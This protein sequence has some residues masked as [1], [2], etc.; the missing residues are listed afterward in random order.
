MAE[1]KVTFNVAPNDSRTIEISSGKIA[2][3][4]NGSCVVR[5]GDT[6]VM[7]AACSGDAKPGQDFFPL[8]VD[9]REKYS[10]AGKFPRR[11]YQT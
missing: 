4:A 10:A 5:L 3:L 6:V 9:Y 1:Q 7:V 8:Q 11:L 2:K